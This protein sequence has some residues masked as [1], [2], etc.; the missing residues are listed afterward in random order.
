MNHRHKRH[1]TMSIIIL[2][3]VLISLTVA[4]CAVVSGPRFGKLPEGERLD[5]VK[6]S[7]NYAD[8]EFR[9]TVPTEKFAE[10]AGMFSILW[11]GIFHRTDRLIPDH[12]LP[13]K[14]TDLKELTGED[15]LVWMG[16]SSWFMQ[17]NGM[18]ILLDP[19]F[20]DYASPFSFANKAFEGTN[21]YNAGDM[22]EIDILIISHDHWDHLDYNTVTALEPKVGKVIC[23][24]GVGSYLEYWG[25]PKNKITEGDWY[26]KFE[27][28]SEIVVHVLPARHFSGRLFK[29]NRTL[30]AGF[31]FKTP[32]R[33][34]FFSG[35]TG[36]GPHFAEIGELFGGFDLAVLDCGQY[37][38]K[39]PYI[40]M[41]PEQSM[42]AASD[43]KAVCFI[44]GHIGRFAIANHP[45]D[46]PYNYLIKNSDNYTY[47]LITPMIGE[48]VL[49]NDSTAQYSRWWEKEDND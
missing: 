32:E 40:H 18:R 21:I 15:A 26:D 27:L 44:P 11:D 35:D 19:V 34:M 8:G 33:K 10:D 2:L 25:Y 48:P 42:T 45:W 4:A 38:R 30:W 43:L 16:H 31:A 14:K 6:T 49:L 20:S 47:R 5:S 23:P 24:L 9:N 39:W 1:I 37:D 22:P 12:P 3:L 28:D 36:Y 13:V 29:N 41:T 46:E 17:L 7:P